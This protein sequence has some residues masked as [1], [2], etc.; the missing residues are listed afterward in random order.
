MRVSEPCFRDP[1]RH[2]GDTTRERYDRETSH[3]RSGICV[4]NLLFYIP[5][6]KTST[7]LPSSTSLTVGSQN[8][9]ILNLSHTNYNTKSPICL[10][11]DP[12]ASPAH[13]PLL[14]KSTPCSPGVALPLLLT[15]I[16]AIAAP[17]AALPPRIP[18]R[19][20]AHP[21]CSAVALATLA[22]R[23]PSRA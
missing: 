18:R 16:H 3:I 21:A 4:A 20:S 11:S 2:L 14:H 8:D 12:S 19:L 13:H 10:S 9:S 6:C 22:S 17:P 15:G 5:S 23:L 7:S 1:E